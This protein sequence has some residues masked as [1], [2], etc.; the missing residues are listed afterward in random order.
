MIPALSNYIPEIDA[1]YQ[2]SSIITL[3]LLSYRKEESEIFFWLMSSSD[4]KGGKQKLDW[5][6]CLIQEQ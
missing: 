4:T 6:I 3:A 5:E 2:F 1:E